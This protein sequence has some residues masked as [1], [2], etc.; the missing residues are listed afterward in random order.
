[1]KE[2]DSLKYIST[3]GKSPKL[4]FDQV[5]LTGLA[6]DNGLY[7]PENWPRLRKREVL[8]LQNCSYQEIVY[9]TTLPFV[10][11]SIPK[12]LFRTCLLYT[13]DAADE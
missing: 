10:G 3:R 9:R 11:N 12:K 13:S 1:M 6:P 4:N 2:K 5:V 7:L 8:E